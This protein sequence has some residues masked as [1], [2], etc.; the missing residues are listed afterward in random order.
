MELPIIQTD[1]KEFFLMDIDG[2]GLPHTPQIMDSYCG[3]LCHEGKCCG[4]SNLR[5]FTLRRHGLAV[6]MPGQIV[7]YESSSPDF[8]ATV[9]GMSPAFV[10]T[11]KFPY[12]FSVNKLI[13]EHPITEFMQ[14]EYD[15]TLNLI[16]MT[17]GVIQ[18]KV[19]YTLEIIRH[20]MCAHVYG[21]SYLVDCIQMH[22]SFT[23][24][25]TLVN[26][27]MT[28]LQA[29]YRTT[30]SVQAYADKLNVTPGY[31]VSVLKRVTGKTTLEWISEY[32]MLEAKALLRGSSLSIKQISNRLNFPSQSAFGKYFKKIEGVSPAHYRE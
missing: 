15:A 28:E 14:Q 32:V 26:R 13:D 22:Q 19:K 9:I 24:D 2:T 18:N 29:N 3:I 17:A 1:N 10:A 25:E 6:A 5:R 23:A 20:L 7:Q 27:F 21:F 16:R 8:R 11:L 4:M 31:L 12:N 30:R